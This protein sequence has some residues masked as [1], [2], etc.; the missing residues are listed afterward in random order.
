M[1]TWSDKEIYCHTNVSSEDLDS[2]F[3]ETIPK[4]DFIVSS[5]VTNEI[6][7]RFV[8][9]PSTR[10]FRSRIR[11]FSC[12]KVIAHN[13]RV[14]TTIDVGINCL[15]VYVVEVFEWDDKV[16]SKEDQEGADEA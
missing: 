5:R 6:G 10:V 13:G 14:S 7:F 3:F 12:R 1:V 8:R 4:G 16:D 11:R 9:L 2:A 15:V